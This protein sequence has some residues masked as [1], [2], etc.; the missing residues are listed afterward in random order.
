MIEMLNGN[1]LSK[2][3]WK[4]IV[5]ENAWNSEQRHRDDFAIGNEH[6]DLISLTTDHPDYSVWL[7]MADIDQ[8]CKR[9]C[10]VM[11]KLLCQASLLKALVTSDK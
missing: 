7:M 3:A 5:W 10:E 8:R 6:L 9:R 11:I 1:M 2:V 4:H